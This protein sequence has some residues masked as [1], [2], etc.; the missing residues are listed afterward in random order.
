MT[1]TTLD[2]HDLTAPTGG[3]GSTVK[4]LLLGAGFI[5]AAWM[6]CLFGAIGFGLVVVFRWWGGWHP[7]FKMQDVVLVF[8][9][10]S[11]SDQ[12]YEADQ[13]YAA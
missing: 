8:S 6:F 11:L 2:H 1:A 3:G 4:R 5:R 9:R 13:S 12:G 7:L 10:D